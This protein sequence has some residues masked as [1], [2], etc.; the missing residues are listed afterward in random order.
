[1]SERRW[2]KRKHYSGSKGRPDIWEYNSNA[3]GCYPAI[4][5]LKKDEKVIAKFWGPKNLKNITII[6]H[7][8]VVY[9]MEGKLNLCRIGSSQKEIIIN[10]KPRMKSHGNRHS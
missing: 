6:K 8:K 3:N 2:I 1:M 5:L 10:C 7:I 4:A 9:Q